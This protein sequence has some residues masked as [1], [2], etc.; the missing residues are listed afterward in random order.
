VFGK[1]LI[2]GKSIRVRKRISITI[3]DAG[4]VI[5]GD[6]VFFNRNAEINCLCKVKIGDNVLVGP[7]LQIFDHDH[8]LRDGKVYP[9]EFITK[10]VVIGNDVWI[11]SNVTILKGVEI[12]TGA[13]IAAGTI[14]TKDVANYQILVQKRNNVY[15]NR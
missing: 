15:L 14:V 1:K 9:H 8:I 3:E 4:K 13:V 7:N 10:P 5:I 12:G 6:N 11:G 2:V